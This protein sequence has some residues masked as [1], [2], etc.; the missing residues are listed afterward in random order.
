MFNKKQLKYLIVYKN[1]YFRLV[2]DKKCLLCSQN[3]YAIFIADEIAVKIFKILCFMSL[4]C[5]YM[6]SKHG[7]FSS[8]EIKPSLMGSKCPSGSLKPK[9]SLS[10]MDCAGQCTVWCQGGFNSFG[11]FLMSLNP[12][13]TLIYQNLL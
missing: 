2:E 7:L 9:L 1:I 11:I 5:Y 4:N 6:F 13:M 10:S 12:K 8:V 3:R